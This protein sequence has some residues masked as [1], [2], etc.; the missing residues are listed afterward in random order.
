M[1]QDR[2]ADWVTRNSM[3]SPAKYI[4]WITH[5]FDQVNGSEDLP[6]QRFARVGNKYYGPIDVEI[7]SEFFS[8]LLE[9]DEATEFMQFLEKGVDP[10]DEG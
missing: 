10:S 9:P 8:E 1:P 3:D 5:N 7:V 6:G 2:Y 4:A